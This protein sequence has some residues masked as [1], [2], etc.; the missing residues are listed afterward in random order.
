MSKAIRDEHEHF[1]FSDDYTIDHAYIIHIFIPGMYARTRQP[2]A[3]GLLVVRIETALL[4]VAPH[5]RRMIHTW[6]Y[7]TYIQ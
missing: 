5:A 2:G 4:G 3:G 7:C 1:S 6:Y